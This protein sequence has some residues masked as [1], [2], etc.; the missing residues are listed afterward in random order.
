MTFGRQTLTKPRTFLNRQSISIRFTPIGHIGTRLHQALAAHD[1]VRNAT[2]LIFDSNSPSAAH[3]TSQPRPGGAPHRRHAATTRSRSPGGDPRGR[4]PVCHARAGGSVPFGAGARPCCHVRSHA[5]LLSPMERE[6]KRRKRAR[7]R[8]RSHAHTTERK[9]FGGS[10]RRGRPASPPA[11]PRR[12]LQTIEAPIR[13]VSTAR[14]GGVSGRSAAP[15]PGRRPALAQLRAPCVHVRAAAPRAGPYFHSAGLFG[16][17]FRVM[18]PS[19]RVMG[20]SFPV[21]A[22][23]TSESVGCHSHT[24]FL[25]PGPGGRLGPAGP[26][27]RRSPS[28][29]D[30]R[31]G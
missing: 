4:G 23:R 8:A 20:P 30:A 6:L 7:M 22:D 26:A 31:A 5:R 15:S 3:R 16:P 18:G 2:T 13:A 21:L 27:G 1:R 29:S 14:S 24:L 12:T 19:F 25:M 9:R 17:S 10:A 28:L 11:R